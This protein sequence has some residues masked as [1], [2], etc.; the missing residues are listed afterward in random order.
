[1]DCETKKCGLKCPLTGC[2]IGMVL[3]TTLVAFIVT[4]G[5]DFAFHGIYMKEAY[6]ATASMWRTED[7]MKQLSQFCYIYHGVLAFAL[8]GLYCWIS[9]F[10]PCGGKTPKAG[11][12]FGLFIGLIIGISHFASYIWMPIPLDMAINWLVGSV[13]WGL[14]LGFILSLLARCCCKKSCGSG[15]SCDSKGV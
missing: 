9:R 12:K 11:L 4:M 7:E 13:V 1:M 10:L 5:F 6:E 2:P 15:N 14:I 3:A 8:A